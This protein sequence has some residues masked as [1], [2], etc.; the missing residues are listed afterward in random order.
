MLL[1][2]FWDVNPV[3]F[4]LIGREVRWYGL[5]LA[6][7]FLLGYIVLGRTMKKEGFS[8]KTID[9][10][11]IYIILG[12][13]IGLRL[14]HCLFYGPYF[15][16]FDITGI[17]I[18]EGYLSHPLNMLKIWEGGLA[19]HGGAMGILLAIFIFSIV[20]KQPY[21]SMLDK[22]VLIVP[23]AG[24]MVRLGNLMNSEIVGSPTSMPWGFVF[25]RLHE[26][27]NGVPLNTIPL[28]PAQLY[29]ALFYFLMFIC[30]Y[31]VYKKYHEK[32]KSGTFLGIFLIILF[33]FRFF[34]EF[35]KLPQT[36]SDFS[37]FE[38]TGI[39][40]GQILSIPFVIFGICLLVREFIS[41][42]NNSNVKKTVQN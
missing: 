36:D 9:K 28:H 42:K 3:M 5:L 2:I 35:I 20:Y 29:E 39:D 25:N 15:D 13:V 6:L 27:F 41:R 7:G 8:Q 16:T 37:L 30:L 23:L 31:F 32:W 24:G 4:E 21:L 33:V 10:F 17:V 34:I 14:G 26:N 11:S 12:T 22:V 40:I 38:H 18:E 19:S 1:S